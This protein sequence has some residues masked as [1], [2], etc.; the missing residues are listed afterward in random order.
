MQKCV[1]VCR[2]HLHSVSRGPGIFGVFRRV[3]V[4]CGAYLLMRQVLCRREVLRRGLPGDGSADAGIG[5]FEER[6]D[7]GLCRM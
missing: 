2:P 4:V 5:L 6:G 3:F 1:S 7:L